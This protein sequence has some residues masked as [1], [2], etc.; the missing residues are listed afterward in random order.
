MVTSVRALLVTPNGNVL[1][2]RRTK[3]DRPVYWVLP[4]GGIEDTD[5]S[6]EAAVSR[7]VREET[8][9]VPRLHRLI[10]VADAGVHG[11]H[12][13]FLARIAGWSVAGQTGPEFAEPANGAYHL[14]EYPLTAE[15][16]RKI[17][18]RPSE[19]SAM[20]ADALSRGVDIFELPDVRDRE[21]I[22]WGPRP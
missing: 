15:V 21:S 13:I 18:P 14:D 7:E 1:L 6:L 19:T 10:H 17:H 8:G 20:V 16:F 22:P 11:V 3:A 5:E 2:M 4:G 9:A 12:G